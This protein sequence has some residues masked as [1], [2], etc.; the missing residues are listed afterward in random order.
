VKNAQHQ[1]ADGRHPAKKNLT[2]NA[3]VTKQH[4]KPTILP[5]AVSAA[6]I[7]DAAGVK[8]RRQWLM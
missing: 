8:G 4:T 6:V 1:I 3:P 2:S 7:A 5:A